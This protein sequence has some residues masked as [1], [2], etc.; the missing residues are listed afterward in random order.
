MEKRKQSDANLIGLTD[1]SLY[2]SLG[3]GVATGWITGEGFAH[4]HMSLL[5]N[6][7]VSAVIGTVA[8]GMFAMFAMEKSYIQSIGRAIAQRHPTQESVRLGSGL[9]RAVVAGSVLG[10]I[11]ALSFKEGINT[12]PVNDTIKGVS[13]MFEFSLPIAAMSRQTWIQGRE[14]QRI[15]KSRR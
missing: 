8:Y 7:P 5:L 15:Q 2:T 3:Y 4:D 12:F 11:T 10:A 9:A 1:A 13:T 14:M 6:I